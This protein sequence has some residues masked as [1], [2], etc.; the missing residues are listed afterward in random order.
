MV[1][2]RYPN[3]WAS[4]KTLQ[5][6]LREQGWQTAMFAGNVYLSSN[7]EGDRGWGMHDA[8]LDATATRQ[9][10]AVRTWLDK[11]EDKNVFAMIHLMDPHLPYQEPTAYRRLFTSEDEPDTLPERFARGTVLRAKTLG[12][13]GRQHVRNRYDNNIRYVDDELKRLFA[14]FTD[15]DLVFFFSDHGEEFW[16]HG[17]FEHGHEF[18]DEIVRVPMIVTGPDVRV[19]RVD[20]PVTLLDLTPTLL[21]YIDGSSLNTHGQSLRPL[22]TG[23][24]PWT[25]R[26]SG[27]GHPLYGGERWGVVHGG[28]KFS[29]YNGKE[30]LF[31]LQADPKEQNNILPADLSTDHPWHVAVSDAFKQP[32]PRA[33]RF[34]NR[35]SRRH[36]S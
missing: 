8:L 30:R 13:D 9:V 20:A 31:D 16:E 18:W 22:L 12:R 3:R 10:N 21:D 19:Q 35:H 1:T 33:L 11:H 29:H 28:H 7:F 15:N 2:G 34:K 27:L 4:S 24:G 32:F 5:Q 6:H 14:S 26:S 23:D 17:G 25:P 36:A